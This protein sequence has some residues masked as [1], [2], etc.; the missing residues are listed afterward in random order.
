MD[1]ADSLWVFEAKSARVVA[2]IPVGLGPT[3]PVA[4]PDGALVYVT[5][6]DDDSISVI[7]TSTWK[8][9]HTVTDIPEPHDAEVTADGRYIY[10]AASGN[11]TLI[12]LDTERREIVKT[13]SVGK[14]PRGVAAG[15]KDEQIAYLTNKGDGTLSII[16]VP[17][18]S[19]RMTVPVGKGAHALRVSPDGGTVYVVLSKEDAVAVVEAESGV[20][21]EKLKVGKLPE[22]IDLSN[23]GLWLLVS[24]NADATVSIIDTNK[25]KVTATVPVGDGA[26]GIQ[27]LQRQ[28]SLISG[29]DKDRSGYAQVTPEQLNQVLGTKNFTL[30]NVHIPFEGSIAKT[31]YLIPYNRIAQHLDRL[32]E[33]DKPIVVYCR[34]SSMSTAAANE[35]VRV[36]YPNIVELKGGFDAWKRS[37]YELIKN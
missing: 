8:V 15:G 12:V 20:V 17:S 7:D 25:L 26:Y 1:E 9:I 10:V 27:V 16:D 24:N 29:L 5:N 34:S 19:V 21:L 28:A 23:D 14:K 22:Q 36:G 31:D 6:T 4:A 35:L 3:H 11:N 32:S 30:I 33:K 37:G 2:K 13:F 18:G